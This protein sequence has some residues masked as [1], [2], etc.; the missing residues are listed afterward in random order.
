MVFTLLPMIVI[1]RKGSR[2]SALF[3]GFQRI[4]TNRIREKRAG[5]E[6]G[7]V[8]DVTVAPG[9]IEARSKGRRKSGRASLHGG[10]GV[11]ER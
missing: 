10:A 2:N 9:H 5:G 8:D 1:C 11:D 6:R 3:T 7:N 4:S